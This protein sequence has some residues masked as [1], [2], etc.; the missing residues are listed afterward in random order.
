[1]ESLKKKRDPLCFIELVDVPL[2]TDPAEIEEKVERAY[3][4]I[5]DACEDGKYIPLSTQQTVHTYDKEMAGTLGSKT[6][7]AHI[8]FVITAHI[9]SH[10]ELARRQRLQQLGGNNNGPHRG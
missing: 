10:D 1:M 6:V 8:V 3:S 5:Q 4:L 2:G 7:E 9:I